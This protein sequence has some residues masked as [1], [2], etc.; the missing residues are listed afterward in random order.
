[1][2][3]RNRV[4]NVMVQERGE[5]KVCKPPLLHWHSCERA[6]SETSQIDERIMKYT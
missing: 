1:M 6:K 2:W 3:K 5:E 4:S